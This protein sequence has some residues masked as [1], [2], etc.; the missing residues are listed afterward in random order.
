MKSLLLSSKVWV[1]V[2]SGGVGKTSTAAALG[3]MAASEGL[4]VHVLTVDPSQRL[5]QTLGI[6]E[7][8][9]ATEVK[10]PKIK[11]KLFASIIDPKKTFD[12]FISR[13]AGNIEV[14]KLKN[15]RLYQQLT[16]TL[17]GSQE[18]TALERVYL[19]HESG[20]F[21]LIVLDTPPTK[22]AIDFLQAPQ[23]LSAVLNE[24][25]AKW[26]RD[27]GGEKQSFLRGVLSA[28]TKTVLK[29]LENITGSE[30]MRELSGFFSAIE[31]FQDKI[32]GRVNAVHRLLV[33]PATHFLL[34]TSFDEAKLKEAEYFSKEIRKGGYQLS[35]I[36]INRAFPYWYEAPLENPSAAVKNLYDNLREYFKVRD[37]LFQSFSLR[38]KDEGAVVRLPELKNEVANIDGVAELAEHL[39]TDL[40][41]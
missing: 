21:D 24:G 38:M 3:F 12:Q 33:D 37:Q 14:E 41:G 35:G 17:A 36:I 31:K 1:C 13:A 30:F 16:T 28:G 18:F 40:L 26:F 2:G 29:A 6:Q 10:H 5:K 39:D 15:N 27:P 20:D 22:H 4:R 32:E 34:V 25:I 7:G 8:Q 11:G 23:K 19:L 9:D